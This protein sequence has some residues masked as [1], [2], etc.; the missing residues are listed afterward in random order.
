MTS[1]LDGLYEEQVTFP[2]RPYITCSG[3]WMSKNKQ[4]PSQREAQRYIIINSCTQ[5]QTQTNVRVSLS[6][7]GGGGKEPS[8][9]SLTNVLSRLHFEDETC[10]RGHVRRT[11]ACRQ[12]GPT[13]WNRRKGGGR[14]RNRR[15][16]QSLTF[17][18]EHSD[19]P[20]AD[21][22]MWAEEW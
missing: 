4:Q 18:Y 21:C 7:P 14:T 22:I 17:G 10:H 6:V 3:P 2:F 5:A 19:L 9:S 8:L 12:H 1:P 15:R 20:A 13:P 16:R 11:L